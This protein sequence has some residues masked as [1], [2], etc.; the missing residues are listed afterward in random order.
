VSEHGAGG[1]PELKL[2]RWNRAVKPPPP[3]LPGISHR[4][5]LFLMETVESGLCSTSGRSKR[6]THAMEARLIS[7]KKERR[8]L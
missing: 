5:V 7:E 3:P 6:E 2:P 4:C 8:A 1:T